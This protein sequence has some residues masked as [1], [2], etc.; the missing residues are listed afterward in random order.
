MAKIKI[1]GYK[2]LV[3]DTVANQILEEKVNSSKGIGQYL[4]EKYKN[5]ALEGKNLKALFFPDVPF[6]TLFIPYIY[7]E[8]YLEGLYID[9]LNNKKDLVIMDVGS[10]IGVT[11][12]Y[13]KDFAKKVYAIEPSSQ[14]FEALEANK[15]FNNWDNV[16]VFNMAIADKDGEMM[17]NTLDSNKTCHS[18][19]NNYGQGG[20]MVKTQAFDTFF[21]ENKIE[22][23]DFMKFDVE[24]AEDMILRS[25]GFKKIAD[26]VQSIE[27][28]FHYPTWTLLVEYMISLG[29]KAKRYDSSAIVVLFYK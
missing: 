14:H 2:R 25:E 13:F 24:G 3:D 6:D 21:E 5:Q 9:I 1:P 26:K 12:Q 16:E 22:K 15:E 27:V 28:E 10:N 23:V 4:T 17:L 29:F 18:L 11:V 20:E 19:I 7:K 8:I